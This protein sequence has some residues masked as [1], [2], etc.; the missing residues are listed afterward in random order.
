[1]F[2]SQLQAS[3]DGGCA[4]ID[5]CEYDLDTAAASGLF[6]CPEGLSGLAAGIGRWLDQENAGEGNS[7]QRCECWKKA[8]SFV[9]DGEAAGPGEQSGGGAQCE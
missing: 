4:A 7:V 5:P 9:N 1:V 3:Y 8:A 6:E 2:D